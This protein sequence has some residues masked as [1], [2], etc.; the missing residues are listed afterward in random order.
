MNLVGELVLARNQIVQ[1]VSAEDDSIFAAP[2]QNLSLITSEVQAI[3]MKTRMQSIRSIWTKFPRLIRDLSSG[4]GKRVKLEMHGE[5]TELD[6]SI[7]HEIKDP[8]MHLIRNSVDHGIESVNE[9]IACGKPSTGKIELKAFHEGGQ[10]DIEISDDGAGLDLDLIKKKA[11]ERGIITSERAAALSTQETLALI[12]N[13]GLST[14][15]K[16]TNI[17][18]RG[19]GMDVVRNNIEKIGGTIDIK[20]K[21]H[22]GT[23]FKIKIP[24]T[25]AIIPALTV[26]CENDRYA[27]PH[28]SVLELVQLNGL[29]IQDNIEVI[30]SVPVY[31]LRGKLI[32]LIFLGELLKVTTL[33]Y[34]EMNFLG[35][36]I[37]K[38]G[39]YQF[40]LVVDEIVDSQEIVVKPL[41]KQLQGLSCYAGATILGD[42]K[43]ALILDV[44]GIVYYSGLTSTMAEHS[45][46]EQDYFDDGASASQETQSLL[47]FENIDG[48]C[49]GVPLSMATRLEELPLKSVEKIGSR[50]AV[51]YRDEI[52]TVI[53][54]SEFL[55]RGISQFQESDE[56][57]K[58]TI[59]V[60]IYS[61]NNKSVGLI[62]EH[63]IDIEKTSIIKD[64]STRDAILFSTVVQG[65]I[66]EVVDVEYII[67]MAFPNFFDSKKES[68]Q[69]S[70]GLEPH[71]N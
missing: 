69:V 44:T 1:L 39:N 68:F 50:Y 42:G 64:F 15:K 7:I 10:V 71:P 17:S 32:P 65:R 54:L 2:S 52:L 66:V 19:V 51:Q 24:L 26:S 28:V 56:Q 57:E 21:L 9:R 53:Y 46:H 45:L 61:K 38:S 14:A 63:I 13:S 25:L 31:R 12:Y 27:I 6:R 23:T 34:K 20:T 58:K 8:L 30:H 47:L 49:M 22:Y 5:D 43:V 62:V 67:S 60:I 55:D 40:G 41:G 11:L 59:Q 33:T 70:G 35:I 16:V 37:L 3:V 48:S 29:E 4:K 36:I 18:G